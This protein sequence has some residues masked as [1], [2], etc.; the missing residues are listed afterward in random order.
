MLVAVT[1]EVVAEVVQVEV[2]LNVNVTHANLSNFNFSLNQLSVSGINLNLSLF[3]E[4]SE[5]P[6]GEGGHSDDPKEDS[7]ASSDLSSKA[8]EISGKK[9]PE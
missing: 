1:A 5:K 7:K 4:E 3:S 8:N 6:P 9:K 2:A